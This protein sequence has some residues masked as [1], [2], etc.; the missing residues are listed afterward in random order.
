MILLAGASAHSG[1]I[2]LIGGDVILAEFT[3]CTSCGGGRSGH[4]E[5]AR[6]GCGSTRTQ[7]RFHFTRRYT[8]FRSPTLN[9]KDEEDLVSNLTDDAVVLP[10][11]P[12]A[13][14]CWFAEKGPDGPMASRLDFPT[15][16]MIAFC[17]VTNSDEWGSFKSLETAA[18][19]NVLCRLAF[20]GS[21]GWHLQSGA[22]A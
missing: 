21:Q 15:P 20:G 2:T 12:S 6:R 19:S 14:F 16:A 11:H 4:R 22:A 5:Q 9:H 1:D 18:G 17:P 8:S 7:R 3:L 10:R 13:D